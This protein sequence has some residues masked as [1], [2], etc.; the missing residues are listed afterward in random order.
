M[1]L[2]FDP[3]T[4]IASTEYT[5]VQ[6][7]SPQPEAPCGD[8]PLARPSPSLPHDL[9]WR[10]L[11]ARVGVHYG[12]PVVP[13]R[14]DRG[15]FYSGPALDKAA[16]LTALARG[17]EILLTAQCYQ[18]IPD[19]MGY[20]NVTIGVR[21]SPAVRGFSPGEAVYQVCVFVTLTLPLEL[22]SQGHGQGQGQGQQ[23]G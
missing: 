18:S 6:G 19:L 15:L 16:R 11:R 2:V 8:G 17:G 12:T 13:E 5:P 4:H 20:P 9:L 14:S 7:P 22:S 21:H 1:G 10:G 23:R 3:E